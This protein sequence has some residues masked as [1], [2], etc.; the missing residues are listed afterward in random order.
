MCSGSVG[1]TP[2]KPNTFYISTRST[3]V[4]QYNRDRVETKIPQNKVILP[5]RFSLGN[6]N[7]LLP[8][9]PNLLF[10]VSSVL[11]VDSVAYNY[12]SYSTLPPFFYY[13]FFLLQI[14]NQLTFVQNLIFSLQESKKLESNTQLTININTS[15]PDF[16][17][18]LFVFHIFNS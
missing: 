9:I 13:Y 4:I 17:I 7:S 6:L 11:S 15:K 5:L 2:S 1:P 3:L 8:Y 12:V 10:F 14:F 16:I 18:K